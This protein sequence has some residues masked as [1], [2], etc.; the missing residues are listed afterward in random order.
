MRVSWFGVVLATV[1]VVGSA[2][3][4]AQ[5]Y[6]TKPVRFIVPYP[7]G[8]GTDIF[9]RIVGAKLAES[10]GQPVV[11]EQR[12]G[13]AGVLGA[14]VASKAAPDGYTLLIGQASNLA[15]NPHL[16]KKLP[17]DPVKD[18]APITLIASSPSLLVVHPSL[19]VRSIRDL[20]ALARSKPGAINYASA[21][22]GSPG[23]LSAE[24]FKK[25]A[26]IDML[27]IPYKG[28]TPALID[29]LAGQASLYFTSPV[30]AQPYVRSGRLRQIAVTSAQRFA[31]LPE[32]PSIAESGFKDFDI[33][34]W[35]GLLVPAGTPRQI[36]AR[37]NAE[38]VKA[39]AQPEMKERLGSQGAAVVTSTPEEFAAFIQTEIGNWGR[40]IAASGARLD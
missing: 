37:L 18:F 32:V 31:P 29:V 21:G 25:L 14:D 6:P 22:S 33:T 4:T 26:Q 24:Y 15:I 36:V 20:V 39:L 28:A 23:H 11:I 2:G 13:A 34:S 35:W 30:A 3:V 7:P 17:Y 40:I 5:S 8:G 12:P 38:T 16:M 19:P 27:H 1:A 10:L 9:A